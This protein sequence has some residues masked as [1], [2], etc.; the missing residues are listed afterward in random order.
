MRALAHGL[1]DQGREGL[2]VG[3]RGLRA[4]GLGEVCVCWVRVRVRGRVS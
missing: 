4:T 2:R 3:V 1:R